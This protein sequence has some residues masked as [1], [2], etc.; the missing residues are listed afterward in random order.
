MC[1]RDSTQEDYSTLVIN[2]IHYNATEETQDFLEIVNTGSTAVELQAVKIG[3]VGY[4]FEQSYSLPA[5]GYLVLAKDAAAFNTAYGVSA[6]DMYSGNLSNGGESLE[7]EDPLGY[8]V[9]EVEYDDKLPWDTIPDLGE[10][11]LALID[12]NSD[13]SLAA[14]WKIQN[15][16]VTPGAVNTFTQPV[17]DA[18]GD[19]VLDDVD[20]CPGFDDNL[21]G[22]ACDDGDDCTTGETYDANC[23][24][25]GGTVQDADNDGI[26]D[27]QDACPNFDDNLIG[28]ACDDGDACTTGET[29]DANCGC[30]GGTTSDSDNDGVCDAQD[31][32]PNFDDSLIG[33]ACDDGDACTTGETYDANCGCSGGTASP[34]SDNDGICDTQ[35]AC[36]NDP[37]NNCDVTY[38]T[39][40]VTSSNHEFIA[41][42][43]L[44]QIDNSSI[45][46]YGFES[47]NTIST[48]LQKGVAHNITLTPGFRNNIPYNEHWAVW[49]DLNQ[50]GDFDDAGEE[51]LS[52]NSTGAVNSTITIPAN[53]INGST[54]M[55][56]G[57]RWGV[58]P[59]SCGGYPFGE[60]EDYTIIIE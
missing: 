30:S 29:Y 9:D 38:C 27:T 17:G 15:Q 39:A 32:C 10:Y 3:G 43:K 7:I 34:D 42:V 53:A 41:N 26:C 46:N 11:S 50:D 56:I 22:T 18:D 60:M 47:F 8:I 49:I 2:E 14:S 55:R 12:F 40:K 28:T 6:F 35:D 58:A 37:N 31:A 57:M 59:E 54:V 33:T 13:N 20:Q 51:L 48:T 44:N 5:G 16:F 19:G 1:I 24:C 25:S 21:I 45:G 23:G 52:D 36:P 4:T